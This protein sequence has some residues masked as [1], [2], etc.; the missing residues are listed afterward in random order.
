MNVSPYVLG[1]WPWPTH[2]LGHLVQKIITHSIGPNTVNT[3]C[4]APRS[5]WPNPQGF[6]VGA[7]DDVHG[8]LG[9]L[10]L[11]A[12]EAPAADVVTALDLQSVPSPPPPLAH[13]HAPCTLDRIP[14]LSSATAFQTTHRDIRGERCGC[15]QYVVEAHCHGLRESSP[16]GRLDSMQ[17]L[18]WPCQ[19]RNLV[20]DELVD[21]LKQYAVGQL[22]SRIPL[23]HCTV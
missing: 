9:I 1:T 23:T 14:F 12:A 20:E 3:T 7:N 5:P 21:R 13:R 2:S 19:K 22:L 11:D 18:P 17:P 8:V 10:V 6:D 15:N 4:W 16:Q